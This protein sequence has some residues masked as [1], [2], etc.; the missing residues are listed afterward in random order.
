MNRSPL[1]KLE[2][3]LGYRLLAFLIM[4][5]PPC[6]FALWVGTSLVQRANRHLDRAAPI[7]SAELTRAMKRP[8]SVGKLRLSGKTLLRV[9]RTGALPPQGLALDIADIRVGTLPS[10]ARIHGGKSILSVPSASVNLTRLK[11]VVMTVKLKHPSLIL[12]RRPDGQFIIAELLKSKPV[13]VDDS[14]KPLDIRVELEDAAV[15]LL[16]FSLAG[17]RVNPRVTAL[18]HVNG[19]IDAGGLLATR[20]RFSGDARADNE[21]GAHVGREIGVGI[22]VDHPVIGRG[23]TTRVHIT[24]R[25]AAIDYW[26]PLAAL[27]KNSIRIAGGRGTADIN[28]VATE[29]KVTL[30]GD[31]RVAGTSIRLPKTKIPEATNID[32][33]INIQD[34]FVAFSGRAGLSGIPVQMNGFVDMNGETSGGL[35]VTA[36]RCT[37]RK[38]AS[39]LRIP[40]TAVRGVDLGDATLKRAL[41]EWKGRAFTVD[42]DATIQNIKLKAIKAPVNLTARVH[43]TEKEATVVGLAEAGRIRIPVDANIHLPSGLSRFRY[44]GRGLT[45]R[46]IQ[47]AVK[48]KAEDVGFDVAADIQGDGTYNP[49]AKN[50]IASRATLNGKARSVT[51]GAEAVFHSDVVADAA[52]VKI[53][54]G[55]VLGAGGMA[56]VSG[57]LAYAGALALEGAFTGI[58]LATGGMVVGVPFDN[59][60]ASGR[61]AID[62]ILTRPVLNFSEL[63]VLNP[64]V[65]AE[66]RVLQADALRCEKV[67]W[68]SDSSGNLLIDLLKPLYVS[69]LPAD[70]VV[71]GRIRGRTDLPQFDVS[72]TG[73]HVDIAR[74]IP[75]VRGDLMPWALGILHESGDYQ[76]VSKAFGWREADWDVS[77]DVGEL[78]ARVSG[79]A[80]QLRMEG[81]VELEA[82]GLG[83]YRIGSASTQFLWQNQTLA[84]SNIAANVE[85]GRVTGDVSISN[86]GNL[87]GLLATENLN[88]GI[89]ANRV[90]QDAAVGGSVSARIGI[91]GTLQ[92]PTL[93]GQ[94]QVRE[95]LQYGASR[96]MP[97]KS[98]GI[99]AARV[100]AAD[101]PYGWD[102]HL[103]PLMA[104]DYG[105]QWSISKLD[106]LGGERTL[107]ISAAVAGLCIAELRTLGK[108]LPATELTPAGWT[109]KIPENLSVEIDTKAD[110]TLHHDGDRWV[111]PIITIDA[112]GDKPSLGLAKF[113]SLKLDATLSNRVWTITKASLNSK[114]AEISGRGTLRLPEGTVDKSYGMDLVFESIQPS[115]ELFKPFIGDIPLVG[116]WDSVTIVAKGTTDRPQIQGTIDGNDLV[117]QKSSSERIKLDVL[118]LNARLEANDNGDLYVYIDDAL[119]R[120][121]D[122][123]ISLTAGVPISL[124][125]MRIIPDKPIQSLKMSA[126][127]VQLKTI[128]DALQWKSVDVSGELNGL[129]T[130]TGSLNKPM[131]GGNVSLTDVSAALTSQVSKRQMVSALKSGNVAFGLSGNRATVTRGEIFLASPPSQPKLSGGSAKL[132]GFVQLDN[133]EDFTRLFQKAEANQPVARLR[134]QYAL[135][136]EAIALRPEINNLTAWLEVKDLKGATGLGEALSAQVDGTIRVKGDILNPVFSTDDNQ[137]LQVRDAIFRVPRPSVPGGSAKTATVN[138]QWKLGIKLA[139]DARAI[140]FAS[141]TTGLELRGRGDV[142]VGGSLVDTTVVANLITTGG[143]LRYPLARLD[144]NRGGDVLV[145]WSKLKS[146][147]T[148]AGVVAEGRITG[149]ADSNGTRAVDS[150]FA[151]PVLANTGA[152]TSQTYRVLAKL[153][154]VVDIGAVGGTEILQLLSLDA[155]PSLTRNQIVDLLGARRQFDLIASGDTDQAVRE[156]GN[157]IFEAGLVPSVFAPITN[158]VR[159]TFRLDALDVTYGTDGLATFRV[160]RRFDEPFDKFSVDLTRSL[161]TRSQAGRQLP[162]SYGVNYELFTFRTRGRYQPRFLLGAA[163]T[164][165]QR[166]TLFFIRGTVNY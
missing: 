161:S 111:D 50:V 136:I 30:S 77:G 3:P 108:V 85:A 150:R 95:A 29:T 43:L 135:A 99:T 121:V 76:A 149:I 40:T 113:D 82:I 58:D 164:S 37:T 59:G 128:A 68:I 90:S 129:V 144:V 24:G 126:S 122:E 127:K 49:A 81:R 57:T 34:K 17:H 153:T 28:I 143:Q 88:I 64:R 4:V 118:R 12:A 152:S 56:K 44:S 146:T 131:L 23:Q 100:S 26:M 38:V 25:D 105:A 89:L 78:T 27:P 35:I 156:F 92:H 79:T 73:K 2:L 6:F 166:D 163:Q 109:D 134:G 10:E 98:I 11:P 42:A 137:P 52:R 107:Q 112:T 83:D 1:R 80:E 62:G 159:D 54:Q 96:W 84:L 141:T 65:I 102:V 67:R 46:D 125:A 119:A 31:V 69:W 5:L 55:N 48:G 72:V 115:M 13:K 19:V 87:S 130:V 158:S 117:W 60:T 33:S 110:I 124:E 75:M 36:E 94:L 104:S 147:A 66:N 9:I 61:I 103:T 15:D 93:A 41:I 162:Y 53:L 51:T 133:L 145:N 155:E 151:N 116:K 165:T 16:D 86:E 139:T 140:L 47:I 63:V 8:V 138:P 71:T 160:V 123:S 154:G 114:E 70:V 97:A 101:G 132:D 32:A 157:R 142:T 20:G 106:W 45:L 14:S 39:V 120:H 21:N 18:V 91:S 22:V 74:L 7:V 148:L